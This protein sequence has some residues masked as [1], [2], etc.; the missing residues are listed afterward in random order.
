MRSPGATRWWATATVL[1]GALS[2]ARLALARRAVAEERELA[3]TPASFGADEVDVLVPIRSGDELL[4]RRLAASVATLPSARVHLLVDDDDRDGCRVAAAIAAG[5]ADADDDLAAAPAVEPRV[6]A[7]VRVEVFGPPAPGRNPKVDKLAAAVARIEAAGRTRAVLVQLDDDTA[8]PPGGLAGLLRG[9]DR[10]GLATAIPVYLEQ[11]TAWSRLVAGFVNGSA[12]T[13]YLPLARL[14]PPVSVNGMALAMRARDLAA[15]GGYD[16]IAGATCDDYALARAFRRAGLGI[17]Q[18]AQPVLL[19]TTVAGP[20]EYARLMRRWLLFAQEVVRR[21]ASIRLVALAGLPAALPLAAV[22]LAGLSPR[23]RRALAVAGVV[24]VAS[25]A[26][27][28]W[29][30]RD[31]WRTTLR[32]P[33]AP[34]DGGPSPRGLAAEV[35]AALL[36]PVHLLGTLG[37]RTVTWRGRRVRVGVGE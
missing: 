9:L 35:V 20:G 33:G 15:V 24:V 10:G 2:V 16:A 1:L 4:A 11:G 30:R 7:D 25:Q 29:L 19:A 3:G 31:L 22:V 14:G 37:S 6:T 12:L 26:G 36:T 32:A 21:D 23:P 5:G 17:V 27:T 13:T 34:G 18:T 8:L 28:W